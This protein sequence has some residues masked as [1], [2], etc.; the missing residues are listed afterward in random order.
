MHSPS[1]GL[2]RRAAARAAARWASSG[3]RASPTNIGL[4]AGAAAASRRSPQATLH[5]RF[6]D[7]HIAE[8]LA[9]A[10]DRRRASEP[11]PAAARPAPA[12]GSTPSIRWPCSPRQVAAAT[13]AARPT[14]AQAR[15]DGPERHRW[16]CARRCR[17]RSSRSTS[18]RATRSAPASRSLVMEAM[19]MEHVVAAPAGGVVRGSR[20]APGDTVFEGHPL[21]FVEEADV[22]ATR[23]GRRR[24]SRPRRIRPDLAEVLRAPRRRRSTTR[25]PTR[26]RGGARPASARR[27]RTSRT[28]ATRD[29][30]SSTARWSLAAQRRAAH[31]RRAD[32]KTPRP[33]AWSPASAVNG[34]LFGDDA[35]AR[36]SCPTTT[37]CW[38]APRARRTTE[39]RPH[40]RARRAWRLPVVLFA[41]GGGG[42]A[43]RHRRHR[44]RGPRRAWRSTTFG[45]LSGLV[46][47]VG[48][49]S[50]RCFAG[51]AA[52]LGCCDV[53]H[54]HRELEHRHGRPGDD[55]G[56]R[57][58][59]ASGPRRSGR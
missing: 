51:N 54:R 42:R 11:A 41:E 5:T 22:A 15:L 30:S 14:P 36:A 1:A 56:R 28:C 27:A 53:D 6:V 17:A 19:K 34:E 9:D 43:G 32:R 39:E 59:R 2:R 23:G 8:L 13:P 52:L 49:N 4:P 38:P 58:R 47:L 3:S 24:G 57:A 7:E 46:P 21:A 35:R 55:R 20:A 48:I 33:T 40:A 18:P 26:S 16:R 50:G 45:R 44:R 31:A 29:R 12:R 10:D 25:G 37:R